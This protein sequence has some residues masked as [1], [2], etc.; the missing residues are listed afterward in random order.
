MLGALAG[1]TAPGQRSRKGATRPPFDPV[2]DDE[3]QCLHRVAAD[4]ANAGEAGLQGFLQV[5][6]DAGFDPGALASRGWGPS[7]IAA[8]RKRVGPGIGAGLELHRLRH[9]W[10]RDV[11]SQSVPI[12]DQVARHRLTRRDL[13]RAVQGFAVDESADL[14]LRTA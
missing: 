7:E 8:L 13:E 12:S 4:R 10:L 9:R 3:W 11:L 1:G 6:E 5:G 14:L 2:S